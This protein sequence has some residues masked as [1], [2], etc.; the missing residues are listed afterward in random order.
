MEW[1]KYTVLEIMAFPREIGCNQ[2]KTASSYRGYLTR[3]FGPTN[4]LKLDW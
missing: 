4:A 3:E 2:T 1:R